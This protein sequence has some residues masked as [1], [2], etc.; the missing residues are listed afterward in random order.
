MTD[1]DRASLEP[2]VRDSFLCEINALKPGNVSQ[3]AD[4]HGMTYSDFVHSADVCTPILCDDK[5]TVGERVLKSVELTKAEVGCNTNLGMLLLYF[6]G[7]GI[8]FL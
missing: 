8:R 1:R 6:Q 3:Y 7:C 4:G 2:V 5:L